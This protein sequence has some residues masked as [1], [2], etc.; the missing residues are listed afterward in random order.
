MDVKC[1]LIQIFISDMYSN[2]NR[3]QKY[4]SD[5]HCDGEISKRVG[6]LCCNLSFCLGLF[7]K[8]DQTFIKSS[9]FLH[10]F[11]HLYFLLFIH[12][13]Y[14]FEF[15]LILSCLTKIICTFYFHILSG[16]FAFHEVSQATDIYD[17]LGLPQ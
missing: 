1:F 11:F 3:K 14:L 4:L 8:N 16:E 13:K 5:F 12:S 10:I 15:T 6:L 2:G 17:Y 7:G 9:C